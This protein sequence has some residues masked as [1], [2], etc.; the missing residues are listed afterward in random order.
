MSKIKA[1]APCRISLF[2]GGT[3]IPTYKNG[4]MVL[5][6]A[7][8]LRQEIKILDNVNWF[9]GLMNIWPDGGSENFYK[10]FLP[11]SYWYEAEFDGEITGG[12]GSSA[13]AAVAIVGA[14]ERLKGHKI[15]LDKIAEKAW[16]IETKK[17]KMFGGKQDQYASA[18]GGVNL[19]TFRDRPHVIQLSPSFIES[20]KDSILLFHTGENRKSGKIQEGFKKLSKEQI[21]YLDKMRDLVMPGLRAIDEGDVKRFGKLLTES[22][23]LKKKSNSGVSNEKI[24]KLFEK[25][26]KLGALGWKLLGAGGGGYCIFIVPKKQEEFKKKIGIKWVDY[27]ID[28]N[29]LDTRII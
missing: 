22:W 11:D 13:G 4:G 29:G 25:G 26:K 28:W 20:V 9:G 2:G 8:N 3:D 7:I 17:L 16:E 14:T 18:Y 21:K 23:E 6:M 15:D 10:A 27:S 24:D 1:S 19:I 12:I 5:N